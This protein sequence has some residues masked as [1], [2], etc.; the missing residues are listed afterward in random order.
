MS[1]HINEQPGNP[2]FSKPPPPNLG[3]RRP[4]GGQILGGISLSEA[5]ESQPM[6]KRAQHKLTSPFDASKNLIP[7]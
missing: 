7:A 4:L 3:R 5:S 1:K 2:G 6:P